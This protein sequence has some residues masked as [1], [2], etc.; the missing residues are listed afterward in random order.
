[1]HIYMCVCVYTHTHT[2]R[3]PIFF[4]ENKQTNKI[5][6]LH[7]SFF[8]HRSPFL[9]YHCCSDF[10]SFL[11]TVFLRFWTGLIYS[12]ESYFHLPAFILMPV[13]SLICLAVKTYC[14]GHLNLFKCLYL[15][16]CSYTPKVYKYFIMVEHTKEDLVISSVLN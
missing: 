5:L 9:A 6:S 8:L 14:I 12:S 16:I 10:T 13:T 4:K 3:G 2:H 15:N 1:M 7:S 11:E